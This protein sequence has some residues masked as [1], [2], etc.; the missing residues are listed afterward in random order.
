MVLTN[1]IAFFKHNPIFLKMIKVVFCYVFLSP[2]ACTLLRSKGQKV[3]SSKI[4]SVALKF[5]IHD[6]YGELSDPVADIE[7]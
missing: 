7:V 5:N 1:Q 2:W 6:Q 4:P 3:K